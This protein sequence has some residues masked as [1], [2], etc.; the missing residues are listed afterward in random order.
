MGALAPYSYLVENNDRNLSKNKVKNWELRTVSIIK[1]KAPSEAAWRDTLRGMSTR[2]VLTD[3]GPRLR[4]S[5]ATSSSSLCASSQRGADRV[6][7]IGI[8]IALLKWL[9]PCCIVVK[10]FAR[11]T[12]IMG[13]NPTPGTRRE[14]ERG[15]C[16]TQHKV[17][18]SGI[19]H[20]DTL[21]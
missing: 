18:G 16:D 7:A 20:N 4:T 17:L 14:R 21:P 3:D 10:R 5:E 12:K 15:H 1:A 2:R 6:D 9:C 19:H 11:N 8:S 13:L